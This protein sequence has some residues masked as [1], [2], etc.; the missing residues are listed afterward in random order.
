MCTACLCTACLCTAPRACAPHRV[1]VHRTVC[2]RGTVCA[3]ACVWMHHALRPHGPRR[4]CAT[5]PL[6]S[7]FKPRTPPPP[8]P[9]PPHAHPHLH[10]Y[11]HPQVNHLDYTMRMFIVP[12]AAG[13]GT[14]TW[15]G[16][17]FVGCSPTNCRSWVRVGQTSTMAHELGHSLGMM[18]AASDRCVRWR[19]GCTMGLGLGV[20]GGPGE[21]RGVGGW[22]TFVFNGVFGWG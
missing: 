14:C 3:S 21:C 4:P 15:A 18:H 2:V 20:P 6:T 12:D 17:A 16:I 11:A 9:S 10:P 8:L 1:L 5:S 19:N 22:A 13:G 7:G